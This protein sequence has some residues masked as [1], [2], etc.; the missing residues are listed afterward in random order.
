MKMLCL[1]TGVVLVIGES[2]VTEQD[3]ILLR[4]IQGVQKNLAFHGFSC[5][6][7]AFGGLLNI[8]GGS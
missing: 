4:N 5:P 3:A 1:D 7:L 6:M 8:L 2:E